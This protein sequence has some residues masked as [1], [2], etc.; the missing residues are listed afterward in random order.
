MHEYLT[1]SVLR[2]LESDVTSK[3][4]RIVR[5]GAVEKVTRW[6]PTL[7]QARFLGEGDGSNA[8]PLPGIERVKQNKLEER[9]AEL[10]AGLLR[11]LLYL[12]AMLQEKKATLLR[13]REMIFGRKSEKRK[14]ADPESAKDEEKKHVAGDTDN[15]AAKDQAGTEK[16]EKSDSEAQP[17]RRG[18]G[19]IPAAAYRGAKKVYCRHAELSSGSPCPDQKCEGKVYPVIRPHGF[20]Q[21]TGSPVIQATHYVQEV[22]KCASCNREYEAPLPSGVKPQKFDETADATIVI[23]RFLAATPGFRLAGMQKMC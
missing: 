3:E 2:Q 15:G 12:V 10:I 9:E 1:L 4:S 19:R 17:K 8:I 14:K 6:R 7:R 13:L 11:T 22:V 5:R 18:H 20:I 16:N 23:I 21:F